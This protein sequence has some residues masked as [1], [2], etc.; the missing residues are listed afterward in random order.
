MRK[1]HFVYIVQKM[2]LY[3]ICIHKIIFFSSFK[4]L[5]AKNE[6]N[7]DPSCMQNTNNLPMMPR[8]VQNEQQENVNYWLWADIGYDKHTVGAPNIDRTSKLNKQKCSFPVEKWQRVLS[9]FHNREH[10]NG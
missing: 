3:R 10:P 7:I 5:Q 9:T 1:S 6:K 4:C 8:Y 2:I